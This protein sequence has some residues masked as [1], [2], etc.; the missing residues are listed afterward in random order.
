MAT[1]AGIVVLALFFAWT[2]AS[3][4]RVLSSLARSEDP[5]AACKV[6][7]KLMPVWFLKTRYP[8]LF[9]ALLLKG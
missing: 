4:V 3:A 2:V 9:I 7:A 1:A 8:L 6:R 5:A